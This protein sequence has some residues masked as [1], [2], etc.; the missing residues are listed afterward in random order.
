MFIQIFRNKSLLLC[1]AAL[2]ALPLT[3]VAQQ[4]EDDQQ[5][6]YE[7]P[8]MEAPEQGSA[9]TGLF[10]EETEGSGG[11]LG[12]QEVDGTGGRG[13]STAGTGT[14]SNPTPDGRDPGGNPDVPFDRNMNA[15]FLA[16]SLVFAA[17]VFYRRRVS[18][19]PVNLNN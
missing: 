4:Q 2:L 15:V 18:M 16:G 5:E 7:V 13:G 1:F 6:S 19:K 17:V 11:S 14:L 10:N 8:E 9:G 12:I 3:G